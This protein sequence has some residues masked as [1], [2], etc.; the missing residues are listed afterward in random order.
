MSN[1]IGAFTMYNVP[2]IWSER[3]FFR[4]IF[5]CISSVLGSIGI[6]LNAI[7]SGVDHK[8]KTIYT[9]EHTPYYPMCGTSN[10]EFITFHALKVKKTKTKKRLIGHVSCMSCVA[11]RS[12]RF[13]FLSACISAP[14]K[15]TAYW[16]HTAHT[17][18]IYYLSLFSLLLLLCANCLVNRVLRALQW[19]ALWTLCF[20]SFFFLLFCLFHD[21]FCMK[22]S[23]C[24][25]V[26]DTCGSTLSDIIHKLSC[27]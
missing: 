7:T 14:Y 2:F 13:T 6:Y 10:T 23:V 22:L 16:A 21:R 15:V 20:F 8:K 24:V 4:H 11:F 5:H 26:C 18:S 27:E 12:F 19:I 25:C 1:H 9:H 17:I 3:V